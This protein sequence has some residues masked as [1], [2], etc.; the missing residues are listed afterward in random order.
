MYVI[1]KKTVNILDYYLVPGIICPIPLYVTM[2]VPIAYL[3]H[4]RGICYRLYIYTSGV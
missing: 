1:R 3:F 4:Y 2:H